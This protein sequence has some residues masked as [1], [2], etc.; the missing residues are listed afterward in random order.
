MWDTSGIRSTSYIFFY[1]I[2]IILLINKLLKYI[3]V[4]DDITFLY[5]SKDIEHMKEVAQIELGNLKKLFN[6]N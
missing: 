5:A 1:L 6:V 2:S 4:A 3:L